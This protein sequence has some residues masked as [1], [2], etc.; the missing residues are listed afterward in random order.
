M[1]MKGKYKEKFF[2][3][4]KGKQNCFFAALPLSKS[5]QLLLLQDKG[6][7][8]APETEGIG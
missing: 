8:A 3:V 6:N 2:C 7:I 4:S 1:S 5:R